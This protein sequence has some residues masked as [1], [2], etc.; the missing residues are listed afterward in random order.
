MLRQSGSARQNLI[1]RKNTRFIMA[2][3]QRTI[4]AH[5]KYGQPRNWP[6]KKR[7]RAAEAAAEAKLHLLCLP[8]KRT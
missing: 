6:Q 3:D 4:Y 5:Y 1:P 7:S 8:S 2:N